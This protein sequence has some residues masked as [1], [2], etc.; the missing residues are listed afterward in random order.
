MPNF[1]YKKYEITQLKTPLAMQA[2]HVIHQLPV[3]PLNADCRTDAHV[4]IQRYP[5]PTNGY[6]FWDAL[7]TEPDGQPAGSFYDHDYDE[8]QSIIGDRPSAPSQQL[9]NTRDP[10]PDL[11]QP[12][13]ESIN[14]AKVVFETNDQLTIAFEALQERDKAFKER[15]KALQARDSAEKER[16]HIRD[17]LNAAAA[18]SQQAVYER[19]EARR[20]VQDYEYVQVERDAAL[21]RVDTLINEKVGLRREVRQLKTSSSQQKSQ[22]EIVIRDLHAQVTAAV[23]RGNS[24]EAEKAE[25]ELEVANLRAQLGGGGASQSS[26]Q[27]HGPARGGRSNVNRSVSVARQRIN[28]QGRAMSQVEPALSYVNGRAGH[29]VPIADTP[30][31]LPD[32]PTHFNIPPLYGNDVLEVLDLAEIMKLL[33]ERVQS[34]A[35]APTKWIC[36]QNKCCQYPS[37][38]LSIG[39]LNGFHCKGTHWF[40]SKCHVAVGDPHRGEYELFPE[41]LL[42]GLPSS[43]DEAEDDEED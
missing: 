10:K 42:P 5:T 16:E 3:K 25:L 22:L 33:R 26:G 43:V 11:F 27:G 38:G 12:T 37:R 31:Q 9:P 1:S 32:E 30:L 28:S 14:Q 23:N 2:G 19:D 4:L 8:Q 34:Y 29:T 13:D 39:C 35:K 40:H 21:Q 24:F 41:N 6:E 20:K 17:Q 15:D 7:P 36:G 18:Q